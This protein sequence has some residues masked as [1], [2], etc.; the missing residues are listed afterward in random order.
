[1][2]SD[3]FNII[4]AVVKE[5]IGAGGQYTV[6]EAI[7]DILKVGTEQEHTLST[8]ECHQILIK[9]GQPHNRA[10]CNRA[11]AELRDEGLVEYAGK[12][13]RPG[14]SN[15][16]VPVYRAIQSDDESESE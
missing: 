9:L 2:N 7:H 13:V 6:K 14:I 11:M 12:E 16:L 5:R 8:R 4:E 1:M 15:P 3:I 10:V